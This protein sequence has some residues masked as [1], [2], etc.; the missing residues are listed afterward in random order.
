MEP[1]SRVAKV[2]GDVGILGLGTAC[3]LRA[4]RVLVS[5]G[6]RGLVVSKGDLA[7]AAV[8]GYNAGLRFL[9]YGGSYWVLILLGKST[10]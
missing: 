2:C 3:A 6:W 5:P 4:P 10:F 7:L 8:L 9:N 1:V